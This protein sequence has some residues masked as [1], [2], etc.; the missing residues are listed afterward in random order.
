MTLR[1]TQG[2]LSNQLLRNINSN[3]IQNEMYQNQLSTGRKIN[4]PS[5]D[6]VGIT[7]SMRYRSELAAN[8]QYQRNVDGTISALDNT[9]TMLDQAGTVMQRMRELMVQGANSSNPQTALDSIRNEMTEL[10]NQILSIGNTVF[11]GKYIFNGQIT[12]QPPYDENDLFTKGTDNQ[13]IQFA[14]GAGATIP[15]NVTGN[16]VFGDPNNPADADDY[17]FKIFQ[18]VDQALAVGDDSALSQLLG[19]LDSRVDK[20][21]EVRSEVGARTNRIELV[22]NRL[23]D[24]NINLQS[25]QSKT[26]DA[27]VA[28][29]ITNLKMGENV[30][31]AAL[32][33]GAKLISPSLIDYIR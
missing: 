8:D 11:N 27:D 7:F 15:V 25:L 31:Q 10:K 6:P 16:E 2:M 32:S 26:E 5:D 20:M 1:V 18:D 28:E 23:N 21:L 22:E 4:K 3:R 13:K 12:D 14:V 19:N 24:I 9:D 30:Y 17:I 29:V 33:V